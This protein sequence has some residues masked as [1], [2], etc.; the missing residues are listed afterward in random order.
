MNESLDYLDDDDKRQRM[1]DLSY[2]LYECLGDLLADTVVW[3]GADTRDREELL[4]RIRIS[5]MN[6]TADIHLL[7]P[8][9][10]KVMTYGLESIG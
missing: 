10:K 8:V 5:A 2:S 9:L 6:C 3:N 1:V 4:E 7:V